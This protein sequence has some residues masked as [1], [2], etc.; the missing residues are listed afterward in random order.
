MGFFPLDNVEFVA[1][2]NFVTLL[3]HIG[4]IPYLTALFSFGLCEKIAD[5][6][7]TAHFGGA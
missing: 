1:I 6:E 7:T 2:L 3:R 4:R 5:I